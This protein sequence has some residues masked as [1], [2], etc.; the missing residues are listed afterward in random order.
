[1]VDSLHRHGVDFIKVYDALPEEIYQAIADESRRVG[2][3]FAG[4]LSAFITPAQAA[5]AG[6]RSIE[7]AIFDRFYYDSVMAPA[8][9]ERRLGRSLSPRERPDSVERYLATFDT[10][11]LRTIARTLARHEVWLDPTLVWFRAFYARGHGYQDTT[12]SSRTR[13]AF[14]PRHLRES[15]AR[16]VAGV[17][18]Q[19]RVIAQRDLRYQHVLAATRIFHDAGVRILAG[20]DP[21]NPHLLPGFSLHDELELLV[22][23]GMSPLQALRAATLNPAEFLGVGDSLGTIVPGKLADLVLL[24]ANPLLDIRNTRRIHAVVANGRHLDRRALDRLLHDAGV[25]AR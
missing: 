19:E 7:H 21:W 2:I 16:E 13:F 22:A 18:P 24:D 14:V 5:A 6:Q 15:W 20:S 4:H 17:S 1:V 3:P 25:A 8:A 9:V 10:T 12:A 23:V 11:S